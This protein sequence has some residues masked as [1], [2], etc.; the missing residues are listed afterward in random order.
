MTG[1]GPGLME[2]ANR[3]A[4][5]VGGASVGCNIELPFEQEPNPYLDRGSPATTSS[6]ARSCCSSTRTRSSRCPGGLGT[7]DELCEALTLIQTGKI[8][9]FPVVL[10]GT[11]YW[12]PFMT[13]CARW[14]SEGAVAASDFD[15]LKVTDDLDEAMRHL[16]THAVGPSG[17]GA[18]PPALVVADSI[19][20]G[21][22]STG[23]RS[24][25][26]RIAVVPGRWCRRRAGRR[27]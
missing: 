9:K 19:V 2:A 23:T 15:L 20:A 3:G 18:P 6:C 26:T 5:D 8:Q 7:L 13:S 27:R 25:M 4:R 10:I 1:G 21:T 14:S 16:E 22:A 17:C 12:Q 24:A 11:A